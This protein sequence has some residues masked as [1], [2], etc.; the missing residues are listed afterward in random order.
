LDTFDVGDTIDGK[1]EI[2]RVLGK[3]GMGLVVAARRPGLSTLVALKVL[4]PELR[5]K[6]DIAGRFAR[7]ARAGDTLRSEHVARVLDVGTTAGGTPFIV[8]E[9]LAGQDL[10]ALI[11][12]EGRLGVEQA[13]D[14]LLQA[15]EAIG[16]AHTHGIIHRDLK[17]GNLF[18]TTSVDGLPFVKVL[19]FGIAKASFAGDLVV[20]D[21]SAFFG[22]PR[23]M[24][25]EQLTKTE[26]AD[27]RSDVWALGVI[28]YEMLAGVTPFT[29]ETFPAVCTSIIL[30]NYAKLATVRTDLPAG[31][32]ERLDAL[33]A[34]ALAPKPESRLASVEAFARKL[35]PFGTSGA[36]QSYERIARLT[37][38]ATSS[39]V[40]RLDATS[41]PQTDT[42]AGLDRPQPPTDERAPTKAPPPAATRPRS[43]MNPALAGVVALA[44][45]GGAFGVRRMHAATPTTASSSP[46]VAEG[47]PSAS[48]VAMAPPPSAS[49]EPPAAPS[50]A[51]SPSAS[52]VVAPPPAV[53]ALPSPP[54][55]KPGGECAKGATPACEAACSAH[56]PGRC[57]ALGRALLKGIGA[58]KDLA[59]GE[60]L[61]QAE[62]DG[63]AGS[64]CNALGALH[65]TGA[66][67]PKDNAKA[68]ALYRRGCELDDRTAC[69]NLG[70]MHYDGDGVPKN[71]GLGVTYWLRGCPSSGPVEPIGC[72]DLSIAYAQ[73]K[74]VPPDASQSLAYAR[75]AC[76]SGGQRGCTLLSVSKLTGAGVTKDVPGALGELDGL[77]AK[78]EPTACAYL[79]GTFA[80][81]LGTDVPRDPAR[82]RVVAAKGC[83][84]HDGQSCRAQ[85]TLEAM[86]NSETTAAQTNG[87]LE[88]S[89]NAGVLRDCGFLGERVLAGNGMT[90]DRPRGLGL[91]DRAC[92]GGVARACQKMAEAGG[93]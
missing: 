44:V 59:R 51:P 13:A 82:A 58:P 8:M 52:T 29:G 49:V 21:T 88:A 84:A 91:L 4:L 30:G 65:A 78:G 1:Y 60:K 26:S 71:P 45:A 68:F 18:V 32:T 39:E 47:P 43:R 11:Q 55:T 35:A 61:L 12:A 15:C 6:P 62:C 48:A 34:E 37:A 36:R 50:S 64:A 28:L 81:G 25:P 87:Q 42:A 27:P 41:P 31:L 77:C 24:S 46:P 74:G 92:K 79:I 16:E 17:P 76:D 19:D 5:D 70:G 40:A 3:G 33:I 14:L 66:D 85:G 93:M 54:S 23:Y 86:D 9:H 22:S 10:A 53:V 7:E 75:R 80:K 2:T 57:E 73:G 90:A 72:V 83:K 89:C 38:G 20:T 69:V 56:A 67:V 63:G